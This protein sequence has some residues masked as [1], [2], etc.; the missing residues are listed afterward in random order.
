MIQIYCRKL[1]LI[2]FTTIMFSIFCF[3][4]YGASFDCLKASTQQEKLICRTPVLNDA[5][6]QMGFAYKATLKSFPL[7]G[8]IQDDQRLWLS[9][10]R[11][12][13]SSGACLDLVNS[14]IK[15][16]SK[17]KNA[18]VYTDYDGNNWS[19]H[20]GTIIITEEGSVKTATFIGNWMPDAYKNPNKIQSPSKDG[21]TC[22]VEV[23]L[24]KKDNAYVAKNSSDNNDR[25]S[26]QIDTSKV[27]VKG[28]ISCTAR[29]GF[30]AGTYKKK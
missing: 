4:T 15:E 29:T 20:D 1:K 6:A 18:K 14:R 2:K 9:S 28:H 26:L 25:F 24:M 5:D 10:Y 27:V 11:E 8:Y 21:H 12:C 13:K 17:L 30:G 3:P 22:N 16:L 19:V 7:S 23:P